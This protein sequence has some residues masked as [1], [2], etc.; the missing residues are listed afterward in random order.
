MGCV[1]SSLVFPSFTVKMEDPLVFVPGLCP[2]IL[3]QTRTLCNDIISLP[4]ECVLMLFKL[5]DTRFARRG[6]WREAKGENELRFEEWVFGWTENGVRE[7]LDTGLGWW[8]L[9]L[10]W[11]LDLDGDLLRIGDLMCRKL[12]LGEAGDDERMLDSIRVASSEHIA[13]KSSDGEL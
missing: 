6:N 4:L 12:R 11:R 10:E 3:T 13:K 1:I 7:D 2:R 5:E 8:W 9:D